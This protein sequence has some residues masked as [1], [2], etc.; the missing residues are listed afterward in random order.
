MRSSAAH[1]HRFFAALCLFL[2]VSGSLSADTIYLKNGRKIAATHVVEEN[3][4]VSYETSAG[5]LS[6]PASIVDRVDR[7]DASPISRAGTPSDRAANL[8]IAPPTALA[9]PPT[10]PAGRAAVRDGSIDSD[11][12]SRLESEATANPTPTA[13]ARVV[14]AE[15]AAAQFEISV[16]DFE[17]AADHYNAGLRFDPENVQLLLEDAYLHLRR[18][19]YSAAADL[20]DRARRIQ[21]DSAEVAKL[22]GWAYYGL[23]RAADAVS[24]WKKAMEL[25]PDTETQQALEKA[26]RDAQE[27]AEYH[28]GE[29][30]HFRLKYNGAAAPELARDVLK[31]LETEFA[32]I[33]AT[34]NYTPPEPIGVI[35]YTNQTFMDITRAPSWSG[36]LNDGRIRVPVEGLTSMTDELARVLKHELTHSFVGQKTGGRC[37]VWLQEGI[38]QFMEGKR[39]RSNAGALTTAFERHME[40]SLNSYETSWLN[41]PRDAASNAY[42]WS[43]AVVE[44]IVTENG[45]D[46]LERILEHVAAGSSAEDATRAVL[47]EDYSEL[48]LA[49]AQ[50][51]HKAYF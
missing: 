49:T 14:A 46:D 19:E 47:H 29:T 34:L 50:Y 8:A 15:S 39:S 51:L 31:T 36:A 21:P 18:S 16:G 25:K 32:D 12:L 42:A 30:T 28:E 23:N 20:L 40:I 1:P 3:G 24:E 7:D 38:A 26:E 4:Q 33:S 48:T 45:V 35:L 9:A 27:E 22:S 10:D 6:F 5:R 17:R 41:L 37:P 43:L 2:A 13:V 44:A 11:L